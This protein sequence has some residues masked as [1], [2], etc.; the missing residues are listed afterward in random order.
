M[1]I[2]SGALRACTGAAIVLA[3]LVAGAP[4]KAGAAEG[5]APA[6]A[7]TA[8]PELWPA[9]TYPVPRHPEH[10]ALVGALISRMSIEEKIGQLV[11]ADLCCVTPDDVR[12]YKLGSILVGGNSG[13]NGN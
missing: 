1:R 7:G 6:P 9:Y 12:R 2:T 3:A 10:E 8:H 5:A 11:Q 4:L 13:P